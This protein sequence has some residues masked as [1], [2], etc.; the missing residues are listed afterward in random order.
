MGNL[1]LKNGTIKWYQ[2][3]YKQ[4]FKYSPLHVEAID[5]N[6]IL[7]IENLMPQNRIGISI[8]CYFQKNSKP[9]AKY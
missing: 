4:F 6:E 7:G 8:I 2:L 9:Y 5:R 3:N 1:Y